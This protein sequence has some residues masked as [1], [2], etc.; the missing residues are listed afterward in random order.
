MDILQVINSERL[1]SLHKEV[2]HLNPAEPIVIKP[3][4]TLSKACNRLVEAVRGEEGKRWLLKIIKSEVEAIKPQLELDL[5]LE[6]L[7]IKRNRSGFPEIIRMPFL[8]AR[9]MGT[10]AAIAVENLVEHTVIIPE[11]RE[12]GFHVE[13]YAEERL[14]QVME[15]L[16]GNTPQEQMEAAFIVADF[17]A[18][19]APA[20][21]TLQQLTKR[22]PRA[23]LLADKMVRII[24]AYDINSAYDTRRCFVKLINFMDAYLHMSPPLHSLIGIDLVLSEEQLAA[25]VQNIFYRDFYINAKNLIQLVFQAN[26][27][28]TGFFFA[29]FEES[30]DHSLK[31]ELAYYLKNDSLENFLDRYEIKYLLK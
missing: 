28:S 16:E 24:Q 5:A 4:K 19:F 26:Q 25:K 20:A 15:S 10:I 31:K 21:G 7:H 23:V 14:N 17:I 12:R 13:Q 8:A 9:D 29:L 1:S 18:S 2:N 11:L 22:Y 27:F 6:L 30:K 3:V